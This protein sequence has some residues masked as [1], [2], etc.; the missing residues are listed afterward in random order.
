MRRKYVREADNKKPARSGFIDSTFR[1]TSGDVWLR[2]QD[3]NLRPSGY[4][5][6]NNYPVQSR[7]LDLSGI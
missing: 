2:G 5:G 1:Q 7:N 6:E 3:L 4:E